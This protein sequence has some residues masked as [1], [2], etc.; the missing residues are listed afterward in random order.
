MLRERNLLAEIVRTDSD[1]DG[2]AKGRRRREMKSITEGRALN[3]TW[4]VVPNF[5]C[6]LNEYPRAP[7]YRFSMGLNQVER[8]NRGACVAI[9]FKK[10]GVASLPPAIA[11]GKAASARSYNWYQSQER[12]NRGACVAI[13]FKNIGVAPLPP[14]IAFGKAASARSYIV[15]QLRAL[16]FVFVPTA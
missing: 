2:A 13:R 7:I 12:S 15:L 9:R 14:A 6:K 3:P 5:W 8:S 16:L 11:F 10:I 1:G 4:R